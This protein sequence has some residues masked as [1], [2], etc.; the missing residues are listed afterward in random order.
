MAPYDAECTLKLSIARAKPN[1]RVI[2]HFTRAMVY[3]VKLGYALAIN[4][5]S[6]IINLAVNSHWSSLWKLDSP[7]KLRTSPR[8]V[9]IV[10][11]L[12]RD[13]WLSRVTL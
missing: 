1:G 2:W 13:D 4:Y 8:V 10:F 6:D 9:C 3:E 7:L 12:V 5:F 11:V